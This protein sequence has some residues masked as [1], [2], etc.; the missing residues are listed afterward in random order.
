ML[1]IGWTQ[2]PSS[3]LSLRQVKFLCYTDHLCVQATKSFSTSIHVN[4][5]RPV[6]PVVFTE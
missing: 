3:S 2:N 5:N 1:L 4:D 6:R